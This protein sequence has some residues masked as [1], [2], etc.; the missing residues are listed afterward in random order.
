MARENPTTGWCLDV[1]VCVYIYNPTGGLFCCIASASH[2]F[3]G[4]RC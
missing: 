4:V 1:Y 2:P 3:P